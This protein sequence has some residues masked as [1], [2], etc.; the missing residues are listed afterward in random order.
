MF[1]AYFIRPLKMM[2]AGHHRIARC[3]LYD[4]DHCGV[5]EREVEAVAGRRT[6]DIVGIA[7]R[8][9]KSFAKSAIPKTLRPVARRAV[10]YSAVPG[11]SEAARERIT[12]ITR[13]VQEIE[14]IRLVYPTTEWSTYDSSSGFPDFASTTD[15]T[16]RDHRILHILSAKKPES[17]LDIGSN[18]GWY[19][20]L[21]ARNGA[22]VVSVDTD[23]PSVAELFADTIKNR[24]SILTLVM[25]FQR[26][27]ASATLNGSP[28]VA[29]VHRL[30]CDMVFAL[31]LVHRLVFMHH[32]NFERIVAGLSAVSRNWLVV[33]FVS[34]EDGFL[35]WMG[36]GNWCP[37]WYNLDSFLS[38]LRREFRSTTQFPSNSE[39][40]HLLLC[41]R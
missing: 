10:R 41:E 34:R 4:A 28:E 12:E 26:L 13:A 1:S 20:Q 6:A 19:S 29:A 3:L 9:V 8:R 33:E 31:A 30:R 24:L 18:R 25:N 21:A 32:M 16:E 23:E 5:Q 7:S 14:N 11:R 27:S 40:R 39:H 35:K 38:S 17:V 15:W 2:A 36:L 22:Q 37:S